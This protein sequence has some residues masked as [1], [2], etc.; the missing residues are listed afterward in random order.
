MISGGLLSTN[1]YEEQIQQLMQIELQKKLQLQDAQ[2]VLEDQKTALSDIDSKLS[3]LHSTL[4]SFIDSPE[5]QLS[6]LNATS[7]NPEAFE[8]ISTSGLDGAGTFTLDIKKVAKR[9][10]VLSDEITA[11]GTDY[12]S[13]GTGSFDI[14]IGSDY[15][16]SINIDTSGLNNGEVLEAIATEINSQ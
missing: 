13:T 9:D 4:S 16:A 11:S 1:P 5:E 10:I 2:G 15:T 14:D 12:N 3:T 7:T 8:L 6:P